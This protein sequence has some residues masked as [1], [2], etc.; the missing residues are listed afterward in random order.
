MSVGG[1]GT[2]KTAKFVR[3]TE[4]YL[5]WVRKRYIYFF[6]VVEEEE[7][8]VGSHPAESG[9]PDYIAELHKFEL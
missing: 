4:V 9:L 2:A 5:I 6:V 7:R 3:A 8:A 1:A